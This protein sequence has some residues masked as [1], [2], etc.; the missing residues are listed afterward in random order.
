MK[1][2]LTIEQ[3]ARLIELGVDERKASSIYYTID[4]CDH[5]KR[6]RKYQFGLTDLLRI[7]PKKIKSGSTT[8]RLR[9]GVDV[10]DNYWVK[11]VS[12]PWG[13]DPFESYQEE[14]DL[15]DAIYA[16]IVWLKE[17]PELVWL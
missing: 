5:K 16:M 15:I 8:F 9:M 7:L 4:P 10:S 1:T 6:I 12:D 17:N 11:Y 3:S 14:E 2:T 13:A